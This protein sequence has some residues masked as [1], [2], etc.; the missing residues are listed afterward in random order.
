MNKATS[1]PALTAQQMATID[2]IMA[3]DFGVEAM[4]L[5]EVAGHAVAAFARDQLLGGDVRGKR[6]IVLC[7]SGGNGGDGM[8]AARFL[9][10]WGA[11]LEIWLGRQPEQGRGLAWHQLSILE[12]LGMQIIEPS[13]DPA[14]PP[15]DLI[16]DGL[17]GFS[18]S[19]A[20]AGA[21]AAL[22]R[23]ANTHPAPVLAIDVPSGLDATSGTVFDPCIRADATL[24]LALP[25]TGLLA[26]EARAV[27]GSLTVADIGVPPQ[28]YSR[29]G[30][31][32]EPLFSTSD[33]R[34]VP[35]PG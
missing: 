11:A 25:K 7:G 22:I 5:M 9:H 18:I 26:S 32:I 28:A 30:L 14:L 24:T 33:F 35:L 10:A 27:I 2:R 12:R 8:V 3:E 23:A 4:Q 1:I 29:L 34:P 6:V 13:L 15:A 31:T 20:P 21:I 19:G 17:L 16:I